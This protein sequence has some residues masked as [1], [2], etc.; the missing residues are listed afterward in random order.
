MVNEMSDDA[1]PEGI[2]RTPINNFLRRHK[3]YGME[4]AKAS[5]PLPSIHAKK[6]G[7]FV[8]P[9]DDPNVTQT[10]AIYDAE[11][12]PGGFNHEKTG[13]TRGKQHGVYDWAKEP[14]EK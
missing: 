14:K 7:N 12:E 11:K 8:K 2:D 3:G 10:G 6:G 4:Q 9:S 5:F 1:N 13:F